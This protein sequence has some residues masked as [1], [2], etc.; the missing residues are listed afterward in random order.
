MACMQCQNHPCYLCSGWI[1]KADP[2]NHPDRPGPPCYERVS[3]LAQG[4]SEEGV[5]IAEPRGYEIQTKRF[6]EE[7]R[8]RAEKEERL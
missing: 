3:V 2:F 4:E 8:L 7:Q 5:E 1:N 6:E